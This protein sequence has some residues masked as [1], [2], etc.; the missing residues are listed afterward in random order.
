MKHYCEIPGKTMQRG[1]IVLAPQSQVLGV[2]PSPWASPDS[3]F[4]GGMR[5]NQQEKLRALVLC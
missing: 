5:R 1:F 3:T 4:H 2:V